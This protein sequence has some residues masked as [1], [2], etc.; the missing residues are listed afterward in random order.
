MRARALILSI[1]P[2]LYKL[3]A[4]TGHFLSD[5]SGASTDTVR[6]IDEL[7]GNYFSHAE[8]FQRIL[9][10]APELGVYGAK[11]S[12]LVYLLFRAREMLE[13]VT[14]LQASGYHAAYINNINEFE[15]YAM[16]LDAATEDLIR[17]VEDAHGGRDQ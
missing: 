6:E 2:D 16:Y 3:R 7:Q 5:Q 1:L 10:A 4:S 9:G 15:R 8:A 17:A 12:N 14:R 13:T 11:L